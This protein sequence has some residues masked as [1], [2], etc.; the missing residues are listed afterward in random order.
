MTTLK[1]LEKTKN[2]IVYLSLSLGTEAFYNH[3]GAGAKKEKR[4]KKLA[5][6][7]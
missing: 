1:S 2:L 3:S 5:N 4:K 6:F 7:K